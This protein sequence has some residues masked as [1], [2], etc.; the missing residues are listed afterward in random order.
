M[1]Y[2]LPLLA[3]LLAGCSGSQS[4]PSHGRDGVVRQQVTLQCIALIPPQNLDGNVVDN[5]NA[6]GYTASYCTISPSN[7]SCK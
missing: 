4:T 2:S 3:V 7:P 5:C 6:V 1:K